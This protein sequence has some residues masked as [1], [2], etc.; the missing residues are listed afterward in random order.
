MAEYCNEFIMEEDPVENFA[1]QQVVPSRGLPA[2]GSA[3]QILRK[4]SAADYDTEWDSLDAGDISYDDSLTYAAG[5]VGQELGDLRNTLNHKADVIYDTA[6]GDI[7]SFPDGAD[8]LPVKGLTVSIE[9]VQDLHGYDNPWPAGGGKNLLPL[10]LSDIKAANTTT[11]TWNGNTY[12]FTGGDATA[13]VLTDADDNVLGITVSNTGSGTNTFNLFSDKTIPAGS[14]LLTSGRSTASG[15][16]LVSNIGAAYGPEVAGTLASDT[17]CNAYVYIPGQISNL[18]YKPMLRL[19][20]VS[21]ATFAP[22]SNICPIS[23]WTGANVSRTGKNLLNIQAVSALND[24]ITYTVQKDSENKVIGININGTS[25]SLSY[26]VLSG[27]GAASNNINAY[28]TPILSA[29][30]YKVTSMPTNVSIAF[31]YTDGTYSGALTETVTAEKD[32]GLVFLQ[33][34]GSKQINNEVAYPMICFSSETNMSFAPYQGTTIPISWQSSAGTVYGGTLE[35]PSCVLTVDR[36]TVDLGDYDYTEVNAP[37]NLFRISNFFGT[38]TPILRIGNYL[39]SAFKPVYKSPNDMVYGEIATTT[40]NHLFVK[41]KTATTT[42]AIKAEMDGVQFSGNITPAEYT[43]T[44]QQL[45]TLLGENHIFADCGPSTVEYPCDTKLYIQK[46]NTPTDDD[47]IADA[48]IAS[49]KYFI[50]N[51]NLYLST[52]TILAGDPIKPGTNC[53]LTNLA[54]AL[55]ALN[56]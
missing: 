52:T 34:V 6:S 12:T 42:T 22:Y 28:S 36:I 48:N 39:C 51:N 38:A 19:S 26:F 13:T 50:V 5:T 25:S 8:G 23:G 15:Y 9:P 35:L 18:T 37:D 30:T 11:G 16:V 1:M 54:A 17:I 43:L 27:E 10:L 24:G 4:K 56:S 29:G 20:T 31:R 40:N 21:D 53:T 55:N 7:A 14:Y 49:G 2:G 3:G 32:V 46:I 45:T 33:I 44:A 41:G 47:M